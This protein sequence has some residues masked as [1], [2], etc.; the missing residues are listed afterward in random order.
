[1]NN[2]KMLDC[3]YWLS[4]TLHQMVDA[5]PYGELGNKAT[6]YMKE[7]EKNY[8]ELRSELNLNEDLQPQLMQAD[9]SG[10]LP[11]SAEYWEERCLAA[12]KFIEESPCDPD[13]HEDQIRAY[14]AWKSIVERGNVH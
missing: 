14:D 3:L 12:E 11:P 4:C 7:F 1:M 6:T 2:D 8:A 5:L 10:S 13:I 9:V